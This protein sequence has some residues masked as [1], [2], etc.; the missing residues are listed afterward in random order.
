MSGGRVLQRLLRLRE[1]QEEQSRVEL[2]AAVSNRN[3][4][5][6]ELAAA[7][8]RQAQGRTIFVAGICGQDAKGRAA[9][10]VEMEQYGKQRPAIEE[11]LKVADA[12]LARR[13]EEFLAH[14]TARRQVETLVS[15][16][17]AA[18]KEEMS[19]RAQQ[20]LDDWYGRRTNRQPDRIPKEDD[21]RLYFGESDSGDGSTLRN[22]KA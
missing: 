12:E 14:R 2:E 17:Q 20:T 9:G 18:L 21:S 6:E 11:R 5:V 1:L 22:S 3:R 13:R 15:A 8:R 10:M 7:M 4:V 19:R 16:E